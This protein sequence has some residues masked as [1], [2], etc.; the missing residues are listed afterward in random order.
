M[1]M[2][3]PHFSAAWCDNYTPLSPVGSELPPAGAAGRYIT[4]GPI[5]TFLNFK[6][7]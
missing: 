6:F 3:M 2:D 7:I 4:T 1:R 5:Y